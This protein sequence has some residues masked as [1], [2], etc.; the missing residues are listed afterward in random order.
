[1]SAQY[2]FTAKPT[3]YNGR[4]YRSRLEA[5]WAAFFDLAGF[6]FEYEPFDLNGWSPDFLLEKN[7]LVEIKPSKD[8]FEHEKYERCKGKYRVELLT[9]NFFDSCYGW[10][11][12][13]NESGEEIWYETLWVEAGNKVMFLKPE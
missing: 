8:F 13:T 10:S 9:S 5:R 6:E 2:N 11:G 3:M 1:M 7:T 12:F 4:L